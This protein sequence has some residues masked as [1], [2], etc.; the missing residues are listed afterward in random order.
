MGDSM[1][2]FSRRGFLGSASLAAGAAGLAATATAA[3]TE[4]YGERHKES[5]ELPTFRFAMEQ[6]KGHVTD[7]GSA[8]QATIKELPVSKGLAGVSMRLNPGGIRELHWHAIAAEWAFVIKG[9]VRTTVIGPDGTSEVNDFDPGDVWY[10]PRGHGHMLQGLGP[11]EAHFVLIF[12]D[13]AFSEFGT[14]ST[15]DWLGHTPPEI[16]SKSLGLPVSAFATFPKKEL[17]IVQGRIPPHEIPPLHQ[18]GNNLA[19][20]THR[21]PLLAQKPHSQ[22]AGGEE[23]RVSAREFPIS[24]TITGVVLDLKPG[25]LRELHWHPNA[26]EWQYYI[27]GTA[28]MTVFGSD[29]RVRTEEFKPGDAGYVPRGYGHY[30]ENTGDEP[31]RVLIGFNTGDYQEISLSTWLAANPEAVLADNFQVPDSIAAKFPK[32]RVFIASKDGPGV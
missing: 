12:D 2:E 30:V 17:Y 6:N 9:R 4:Q 11:G 22:F 10:F 5:S 8:R 31:L 26:D 14:F 27:K 21:Y 1:S 28:R 32:Q 25:G 18:G 19:H 3:Q 23:R 16:L 24:A 15:T 13:G 7:G 20:L 29:G